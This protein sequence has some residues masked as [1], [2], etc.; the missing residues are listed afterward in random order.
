MKKILLINSPIYDRKVSDKEDYLP[1]YGLG[2]IATAL[3]SNYDVRIIDAVYNNYTVF[4]LLEII[5]MEQPDAIG[6]NKFS[7]NFD[8]VKKLIEECKVKTKFIIGGKST[9]FL[10][11]KIIKFNTFNEINVT[12]GE[13]EYITKD[14][15]EGTMRE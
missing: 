6:I 15:I 14:I 7:V 3:E 4:E 1:P 8:L 13:G 10:Y 5:K 2:Y 9:R 11:P 12:I